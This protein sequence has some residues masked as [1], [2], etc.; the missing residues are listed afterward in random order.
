MQYGSAVPR[1]H[2]VALRPP[3]LIEVQVAIPQHCD[4]ALSLQGINVGVVAGAT[5]EEDGGALDTG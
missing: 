3:L 1:P 4:C 5:D 2:L